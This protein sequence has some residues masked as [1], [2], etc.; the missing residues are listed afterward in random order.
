MAKPTQSELAR[1]F[2]ALHDGRKTLLLPNAWDVASARIFEDA[3]FP[4]VGT[5]SAGVAFA[6]GYP[7]GQKISDVEVLGVVH[8]IAEAVHIPV[9]ADVEAGYGT[10]PEGAAETAR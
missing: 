5:S 1:Q 3:G 9:T 4:A 2:L 6:L 8:R 10:K 7:G